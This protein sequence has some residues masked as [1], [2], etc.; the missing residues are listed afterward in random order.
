MAH[1]LTKKTFVFFRRL[2]PMPQG[3]WGGLERLMLDW[4]YRVDTTQAKIILVVTPDWKERF[5]QEAT[6]RNIDLNVVACPFSFSDSFT[7]SFKNTY[8]LLKTLKPYAVIFF[9]GWYT[10]FNVGNL[11]ASSLLTCGRVYMHENLGAP[12]PPSRISKKYL[13]FISGIGLWWHLNRIKNNIR[14][15]FCRSILVVSQELQHR[16][17]QWWGYNPKKIRITYH[18]VDVNKFSPSISVRTL[19]RT[20]LNISESDIIIITTGRFASQ[21]RPERAIEA[22]AQIVQTQRNVKLLM[23]GIGPLEAEM[24]ELVKK[25]NINDY[26]IFLGQL[27]EPSEYLKM[28]DIFLL[29]SDN[30]GL[31]LALLEAMACG[32]ICLST[33]CT[34]SSEVITQN[35]NGYIV[36]KSIPRVAEGL[37]NIL[38]LSEKQQQ[39]MST[40]GVNFVR[41]N[42]EINK[43]VKTVLQYMDAPVNA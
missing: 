35:V 16:Y 10:E 30:E 27:S 9:Q 14:T 26:V 20:K 37:R 13:G 18:G 43:N 11:A 28:S 17:V 19:M 21:K 42:F 40:A 12:E 4:F 39:V 41:T 33:N 8:A 3:E 7:D 32:L 29:S 15:Y 2:P 36:E 5:S 31:S 24:K 23:A 6:K 22:F 1:S 38:S 25:L 34:G